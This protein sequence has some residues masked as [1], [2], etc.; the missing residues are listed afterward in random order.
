MNEVSN[1]LSNA[2]YNSAST[3]LESLSRN[4]IN[5][6]VPAD[7]LKQACQEFEAIF[8]KQMLDAMRKTVQKSELTQVSMSEDI[9][10]DMLYDEYAKSF[11]RNGSLGLAQRIYEQLTA[12]YTDPAELMQNIS[13]DV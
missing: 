10:E 3:Q 4:G 6:A 8:V 9:F 12:V 5:S 13:I 1:S 11:S 7:E 2:K